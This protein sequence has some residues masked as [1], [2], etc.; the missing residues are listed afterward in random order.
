MQGLLAVNRERIAEQGVLVP[1]PTLRAVKGAMG[2]GPTDYSSRWTA[3]RA[4]L[5][6][7]DGR[8]AVISNEMISSATR[9]EIRGLMQGL[10]RMDVHVIYSARDLSRVVPAMWQTGLRGARG[11]TWRQYV[12]SLKRPNRGKPTWG[13]R[14]WQ[15]QDAVAVLR[16]WSRHLPPENL[17]VLTVPRQGS[18]SEL[19]W[20]RFCTIL[21]VDPSGHDIVP[22]RSNPSLGTAEAELLRR[23]NRALSTDDVDP[24]DWMYWSR[25]LGRRLETREQMTRF[26]L[27]AR[28]LRWVTRQSERAIARLRDGDYDVVG[29][30]ADLVPQPVAPERARHPSDTSDDAVLE[31]AVHTIAL[32]TLEEDAFLRRGRT[33]GARRRAGGSD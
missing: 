21:G 7:W 16:R 12:R 10:G 4:R 24:E 31:V 25:W 2:R 32:M 8:A 15:S 30:L 23:V 19:L 29:D 20:Q 28:D 27:P 26:S 22:P 3:L 5:D 11:F 14:F 18:P 33:A 13:K 9:R 6:A 1:W 17:H